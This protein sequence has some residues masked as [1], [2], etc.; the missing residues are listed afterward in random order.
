[1]V[2]FFFYVD[3]DG[4]FPCFCDIIVQ[5]LPQLPMGRTNRQ[6]TFNENS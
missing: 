5:N 2:I 1:M 3:I 4:I 6:T